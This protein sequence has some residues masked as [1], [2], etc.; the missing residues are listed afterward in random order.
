MDV[1]VD[2]TGTYGHH[3]HVGLGGLP[4]VGERQL[5]EQEGLLYTIP[6]ILK[7]SHKFASGDRK[8]PR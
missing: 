1:I 3:N 7:E 5:G 2:V 4:A 8:D 6:D